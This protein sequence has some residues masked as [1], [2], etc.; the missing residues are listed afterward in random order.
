MNMNISRLF[1][2][3]LPVAV[4]TLAA[5]ITAGL[6]TPGISIGQIF[7]SDDFNACEID[8]VWTV[9]DPLGDGGT[10]TIVNGYTDD[11]AVAIS[12]PGGIEHEIWDGVIGAPHI[13]Q[14]LTDIDLVAEVK[15]DSTLPMINSQEGILVLQDDSTWLRLEFYRDDGGNLRLAA[16]GGPTNVFTDVPL[17]GSPTAPLYMRVE[18]VGDNWTMSWSEDGTRG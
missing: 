11:A 14:P 5:I 9:A 16:V 2:R 15:F 6:A 7:V 3:Q 10:A 8:P 12:V 13:I 18:R 4:F 1:A 17:P